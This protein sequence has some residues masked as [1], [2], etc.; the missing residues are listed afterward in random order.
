[1]PVHRDRLSS[2]GNAERGR[3]VRGSVCHGRHKVLDKG[4]GERGGDAVQLSLFRE[5]VRMVSSRQ[6]VGAARPYPVAEETLAGTVLRRWPDGSALVRFDG[7]WQ[8][9]SSAGCTLLVSAADVGA[10]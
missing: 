9:G 10:A 8:L 7:P 1:M 3:F 4:A 2:A 6:L 5:R